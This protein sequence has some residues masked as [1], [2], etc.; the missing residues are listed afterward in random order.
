MVC[1]IKKKRSSNL[2]TIFYCVIDTVYI[3]SWKKLIKFSPILVMQLRKNRFFFS[4]V[5]FNLTMECTPCVGNKD[6]KFYTKNST[7]KEFLGTKVKWDMLYTGTI[8]LLHLCNYF[9]L[10]LFCFYG[11]LFFGPY[12]LPL[13]LE[14]DEN[15]LLVL[16]VYVL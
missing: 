10:S 9:D 2:V 7:F 14:V 6:Q 11:F 4:H 3:Y 8:I 13:L 1:F 12:L 5:V 15:D 16:I